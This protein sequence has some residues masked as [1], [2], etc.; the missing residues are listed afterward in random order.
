MSKR[1]FSKSDS[2][3]AIL[4]KCPI[5]GEELEYVALN[6]YSDVYR[7]LKNGKISKTRKFRRDEGSMECGFI[8]CSKC[9]FHTDCDFDTDTTEDYKHIYIHENDNHQFMI[10]TETK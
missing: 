10:E 5:C 9:E 4:N 1:I 7:I 8:A 2:K 3:E 6:Q